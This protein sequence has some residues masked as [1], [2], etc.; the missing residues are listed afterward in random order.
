MNTPDSV[1]PASPI[2]TPEDRVSTGPLHIQNGLIRISWFVCRAADVEA[3]YTKTI[4][5]KVTVRL[6][7]Q[8]KWPFIKRMELPGNTEYHVICQVGR[9][10][11]WLGCQNEDVQKWVYK[12]LYNALSVSRVEAQQ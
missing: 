11:F 7:W 6:G 4:T 10:D 8:W 9:R 12:E 1:Q 5:E 3:V 2:P